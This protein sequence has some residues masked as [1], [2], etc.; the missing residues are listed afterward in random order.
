LHQ[1]LREKA[2]PE[3]RGFSFVYS[4]L[5]L[6][7]LTALLAALL[8]ALL[9]TLIGVLLVLLATLLVLL[10][11]LLLVLAALLLIFVLVRI[12]RHGLFTPWRFLP[13]SVNPH[14]LA[15][16]PGTFTGFASC[17]ECARNREWK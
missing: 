10:A 16:F 3:R 7:L 17:G 15:S 8:T 14:F 11:A 9:A 1:A 12:V 6:L 5:A 4:G 2:L 13:L